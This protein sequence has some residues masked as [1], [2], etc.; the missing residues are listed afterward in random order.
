MSREDKFVQPADGIVITHR[1]AIRRTLLTD[2]DLQKGLDRIAAGEDK[3][4]VALDLAHLEVEL[5]DTGDD[6]EFAP[7]VLAARR[8]T[9]V[10]AAA[11]SHL[12]KVTVAIRYAFAM[13]R[14]A[15]GKSANVEASV[16]AV[17]AALEAVLPATLRKVATSGGEAG[18]AMLKARLKTAENF[19]TAKD[20]TKV[21]F[22]MTFDAKNQAVIDWADRHAAELIDGITETTR[23]DIN[24]AVAAYAEDGDWKTYHAEVLDAVGNETRADMIARTETMLAANEGQRQAW[25]Q[26]VE[27]GLLTG[28]D[29][30][31]WIITPIDAC[32]E[33]EALDGETR[34]LNGEYP[35]PGGDGPPLHPNC[36]CTEGIV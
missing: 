11:D 4:A 33:C 32:P 29:K 36:R 9:L 26:A 25:D 34:D 30:A 31:T 35:D 15:L 24:N 19:R 18:L 28:D 16:A 12:A 23:E 5:T 10:H 21:S 13:G 20:T 1:A 22:D 2:E 27:K 14:K 3:D 7:K 8:E 17:R 6:E